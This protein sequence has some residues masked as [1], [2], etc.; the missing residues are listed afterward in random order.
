MHFSKN[1][2]KFLKILKNSKKKKSKNENI[3]E[4]KKKIGIDYHE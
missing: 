3:L 2:K 1:S 4:K